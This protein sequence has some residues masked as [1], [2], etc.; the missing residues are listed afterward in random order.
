[1]RSFLSGGLNRERSITN[2]A[3]PEKPSSPDDRPGR[4]YWYRIVL[5]VGVDHF[6]GRAVGHRSLFHLWHRHFPHHAH[7]RGNG[8]RRTRV[9]L[10]QLLCRQILGTLPGVHAG[11]ELLV[12]LRHHQHG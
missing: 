12:L 5:R 9:R 2:A 3:R 7:V 6:P 1:M 11:L 8:R 4:R 10:L